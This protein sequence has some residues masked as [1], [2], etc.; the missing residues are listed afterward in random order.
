MLDYLKTEPPAEQATQ[1]G[2]LITMLVNV[3][4]EVSEEEELILAELTGLIGNYV[5]KDALQSLF[6]VAVIP[7]NPQQI[8]HAEETLKDAKRGEIAGG[9]AFFTGPFYSLK[10]AE[11]FPKHML[12]KRFVELARLENR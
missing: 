11:K 12:K 3:D 5:N 4:N 8:E 7:Q 1:L 2:D 10:Y 9:Q 6:N